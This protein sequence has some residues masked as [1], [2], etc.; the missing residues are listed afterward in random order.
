MFELTQSLTLSQFPQTFLPSKLQSF[1]CDHRNTDT[2][3]QP[4]PGLTICKKL[5]K[6]DN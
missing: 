5:I 2:D 3:S 1:Y 4:G 6:Y